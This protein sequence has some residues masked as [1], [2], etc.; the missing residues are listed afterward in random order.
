MRQARPD[1]LPSHQLRLVPDPDVGWRFAPNQRTQG[2]TEWGAPR[3]QRSNALGF[4]DADHSPNA[5]PGVRRVAFLGDSF[6]AAVGV[7][8]EDSFVR[9]T[10]RE[11][12]RLPASP[13]WETLNFGLPSMGTVRERLVWKH[14]AS[15]FRPD[16]VVLAFFLGNDVANNMPGYEK[17][18]EFR[19]EAKSRSWFYRAFLEPSALYQQF[20]LVQ[21]NLR[22]AWRTGVRRRAV[23]VEDAGK[24]FWQRSYAPLDWQGYLVRP[25]GAVLEGWKITEAEILALQTEVRASG[26]RFLVALIPGLEAMA[27]EKFRE[28]LKRYPGLEDFELDLDYPRRRLMGFLDRNRIPCVDLQ[29]EFD[30]EENAAVRDRL[31]F[32]FDQHFS[33]VG[34]RI[35][36][37]ALARALAAEGLEKRNRS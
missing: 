18:M 12:A 29:G 30:A 27:P 14:D 23:S 3:R 32:K 36:G 16:L 6:T 22:H 26:G 19:K 35:A 7:D 21:R 11:L 13:S 9:T 25:E 34:H 4:S 1:L 24:P 33:P 15:R 20:K 10:E 17:R 8:F 28:A 31:Y 5:A 37:R 2:R